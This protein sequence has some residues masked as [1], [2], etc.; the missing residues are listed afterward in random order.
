MRGSEVAEVMA[1]AVDRIVNAREGVGSLDRAIET[2]VGT[3][4]RFNGKEVLT[5]LE[6]YKAKMLMRDIPADR[7]LSGFL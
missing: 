5:Y 2:I 1:V 4:G 3:T 7:W 6:A